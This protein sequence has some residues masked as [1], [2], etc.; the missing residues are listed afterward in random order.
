MKTLPASRESS[1]ERYFYERLVK[2]TRTKQRSSLEPGKGEINVPPVMLASHF[3]LSLS[4]SLSSNQTGTRFSN[5]SRVERDSIVSRLVFFFFAIAIDEL[6]VDERK[7]ETAVS[8]LLIF[9]PPSPPWRAWLENG[10]SIRFTP[11]QRSASDSPTPSGDRIVQ[12]EMKKSEAT[13]KSLSTIPR[14]ISSR[15]FIY[16]HKYIY[17]YTQRSERIILTDFSGNRFHIEYIKE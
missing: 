11:F 4:L 15:G 16:T 6:S 13:N 2:L 17:I 10:R 9:Q 12:N 1:S 7:K 5:F 8:T 3:F 14:L